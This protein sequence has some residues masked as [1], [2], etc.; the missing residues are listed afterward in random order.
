MFQYLKVATNGT[1]TLHY[2]PSTGIALKTMITMIELTSINC[3]DKTT[4]VAFFCFFC[5]IKHL[6]HFWVK[7]DIGIITTYEAIPHFVTIT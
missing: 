3:R 7:Y 6:S 5:F 1:T 2:K 4:L